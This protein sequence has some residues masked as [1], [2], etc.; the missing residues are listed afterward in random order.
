MKK[1][2]LFQIVRIYE[3]VTQKKFIFAAFIFVVTF[4]MYYIFLYFLSI[5]FI[6][7][8]N[9]LMFLFLAA[10]IFVITFIPSI[11]FSWLFYKQSIDRFSFIIFIIAIFVVSF[12]SLKVA[13]NYL[14][15]KLFIFVIPT[16]LF[17]NIGSFI[18][19]MMNILALV[20]AFLL[21]WLFYKLD[22]VLQAKKLKK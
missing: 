18:Y 8:T 15:L 6:E 13:F 2:N 5:I 14:L 7:A 3:I 11:F 4:I 16:K 12:V 17:V 22:K 20:I 9:L 1:K 10:F 21:A 19:I